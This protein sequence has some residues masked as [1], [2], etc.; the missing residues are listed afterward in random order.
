MKDYSTRR[1]APAVG[2][3]EALLNGLA[4][5]GGLYYP[6]SIPQFS[7]DEL[8]RLENLR[9]LSDLHDEEAAQ[10]FLQIKFFFICENCAGVGAIEYMHIQIEFCCTKTPTENLRGKTT[11]AH[12]HQ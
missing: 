4:P 6:S 7:A 10:R 5:D 1:Q 8:A 11:A 12:A 3:E 9:Q 2:F